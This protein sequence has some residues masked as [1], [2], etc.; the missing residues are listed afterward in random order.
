MERWAKARPNVQFL[1]VCVDNQGVAFQFQSEFG[2]QHALNCWIP[3]RGYFPV[4]YGQLG[5]SGFIVSDKYGNFVSRKTK[6]YLDYRQ[7][8][9]DH[10]EE[11]LSKL[12]LVSEAEAQRDTALVPPRQLGIREEEEVI[13]TPEEEEKKTELETSSS[14]GVKSLDDDHEQCSIAISQLLKAQSVESLR[15]VL[16]EL[17]NHF[18]HEEAL[19][20]EYNFGNASDEVNDFSAF[21]SHVKDHERI[22]TMIRRE[23]NAVSLIS[24]ACSKTKGCSS[25]PTVDKDLI[26][27]IVNAFHT[28]TEKFDVLYGD[29]IP[30]NAS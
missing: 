15:A 8:A 29:H 28:H 10:V 13:P 1:C 9:F 25:V 22:L 14:V 21:A 2:F 11:I 4:G 19:M 24:S 7:A 30:A 23:I 3:S 12:L 18:E 17:Q 20:K 6:A 27:D 26:T 16:N 5:C